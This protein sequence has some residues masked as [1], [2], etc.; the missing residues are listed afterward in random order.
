MK[1][2]KQIGEFSKEYSDAVLQLVDKI[3]SQYHKLHLLNTEDNISAEELKNYALAIVDDIFQ[4]YDMP[5]TGRSTDDRTRNKKICVLFTNKYPELLRNIAKDIADFEAWVVNNQSF[6]RQSL[7]P[8]PNIEPEQKRFALEYFDIF[9]KAKNDFANNIDRNKSTLLQDFFASFNSLLLLKHIHNYKIVREWFLQIS[10]AHER[11]AKIF[12]LKVKEKDELIKQR[13]EWILQHAEKINKMFEPK[14]LTGPPASKTRTHAIPKEKYFRTVIERQLEKRVA[15]L[16][17]LGIEEE[18]A[19]QYSA[20]IFKTQEDPNYTPDYTEALFYFIF[21]QK[22]HHLRS[23][24]DVIMF[25]LQNFLEK[26]E[27]IVGMA[28]EKSGLDKVD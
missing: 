16:T 4:K 5:R 17:S 19:R 6:L 28:R 26:H 13:E 20:V 2:R 9:I 22:Y 12:P 1:E 24:I 7:T 3:V 23:Q 11:F 25:S 21:D 18:E 10:D 27:D 15:K 8:D 14:V